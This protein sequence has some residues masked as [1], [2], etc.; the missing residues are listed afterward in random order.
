MYPMALLGVTDGEHPDT[1]PPADLPSCSR[2][3]VQIDHCDNDGV[4][5]AQVKNHGLVLR[6]L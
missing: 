2:L 6:L 3:T 1:N 5:R 4:P